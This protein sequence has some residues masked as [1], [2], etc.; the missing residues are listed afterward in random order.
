MQSSGM[1]S[2]WQGHLLRLRPACERGHGGSAPGESL[3]VPLTSTVTDGSLKQNDPLR[4]EEI[5]AEIPGL[6]RFARTLSHDA[7]RAE[8]L[9][10]DTVVRALERRSSFARR[11]SV[12]TWLHTIMHNLAVDGHRR[13]GETPVDVRDEEGH[14]VEVL[15]SDD[16]YT[17]DSALVVERAQTRAN[18]R[19]ALLRVPF[20][21][22]SAIVLHDGEGMSMSAI[23][24]IQHIGLPAA[25]QRLRRGRMML[26]TA[27]ADADHL[28][29]SAPPL[30]CWDARQLVS[31]YID[32][33]LDVRQRGLLE[34]HLQNCP[35]CPALYAGLVGVRAAV[36]AHARDSDEAVPDDLA[37]RIRTLGAPQHE[38]SRMVTPT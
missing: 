4:P 23:A 13:T 17:V 14:P 38:S 2:M 19:D 32:D 11:S 29:D 3:H 15:W 18:L 6:R 10:Q 37:A 28:L 9:V 21:Y 33:D 25:K 31:D 20:I 36:G 27:L 30:R 12:A 34:I 35:T 16:A 5:E 24:E 26:V 22:R 7:D 1:P 8:D